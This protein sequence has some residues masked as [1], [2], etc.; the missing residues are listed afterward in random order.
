MLTGKR[1]LIVIAGGIAA[2]KSLELIRLMRKEGCG[3]KVIMTK[4]A[5]EFSFSII[6]GIPARLSRDWVCAVMT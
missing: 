1:I 3:V 2:Y 4:A 5:G 6:W